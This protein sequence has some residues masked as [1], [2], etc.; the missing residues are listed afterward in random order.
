ETGV[1]FGTFFTPGI[2]PTFRMHTY[3]YTAG[4]N[5]YLNN[6]VKYQFNFNIDQLKEPSTIGQVPGTYFVFLNRIQFRF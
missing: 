6:W 3:E 2:V 1:D 5:W 4:L